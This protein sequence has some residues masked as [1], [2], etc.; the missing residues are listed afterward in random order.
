VILRAVIFGVAAIAAAVAIW[1]AVDRPFGGVT[2]WVNYTAK[3][4]DG[5]VDLRENLAG[6]GL[7][8][9]VSPLKEGHPPALPVVTVDGGFWDTAGD[10]QRDV[11]AGIEDVGAGKFD[12]CRAP[13][14]GD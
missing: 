4:Y 12:Q 5:A 11:T 13:S 14:L 3:T 8:A 6:R 2:C 7:S 1:W 9:S 10:L